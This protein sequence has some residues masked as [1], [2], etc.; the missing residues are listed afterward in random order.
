MIRV[1]V[2]IPFFNRSHTIERCLISVQKQTLSDFECLIIDDGSDANEAS[3]LQS[4]TSGLSDQR[5]RI[6]T[7]TANRGGGAARNAG[8]EQ[9]QGE[10]IAFLDSDDEWLPSKLEKQLGLSLEQGLPFISCQS[11]VH[12]ADGIGVLPTSPLGTERVSDYLF[13]SNGWLPT[14]SFFLKRG[15]L[16]SIRFDE[17]LPRHQDYD[18]L[19]KLENLG[20]TTSFVL[21]PLVIVHWE[22][23]HA[24]GRAYNIE[25]SKHFLST[26]RQYFS[27]TS[28]SCFW[29]QFVIIP[30]TIVNGR[31]HGLRQLLQMNLRFVTKNKNLSVNLI[32]H[33][34][35]RDGRI[36]Q[37]IKKFG[38]ILRKS[39]NEITEQTI[40]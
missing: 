8:I 33:L 4:I 25:N 32:S 26:R 19:L 36:L 13:C 40:P 38:A 2:I 37:W 20:V 29:A 14:P 30:S 17:S 24:S 18:L 27:D 23:M 22:D 39:S 3:V 9:A 6:I 7:L 28:A 1:S 31:I 21:E 11:Y 15:A 16:D 5:F 35:F 34:I 12:H 10:Y